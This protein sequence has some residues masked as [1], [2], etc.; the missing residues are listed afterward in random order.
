MKTQIVQTAQIAPNALPINETDTLSIT[1]AVVSQVEDIHENVLDW[2]ENLW[3]FMLKYGIK[4]LF[5]IIVFVLT[6]YL[7]QIF[8]RLLEKYL[9]KKHLNRSVV[10]FLVNLLRYGMILFSLAMITNTLG[11]STASILTLLGTLSLTIGLALQGALS[12]VAAGFLL[13]VLKPFEVGDI[14]ESQGQI[15]MV[16]KIEIFTTTIITKN[17]YLVILPNN[18]ITTD[19]VSNIS[20]LSLKRFEAHVRTENIAQVLQYKAQ[21][22]SFLLAQK[23]LLASEFGTIYKYDV[24]NFRFSVRF[25]CAQTLQW[26][27]L[28]KLNDTWQGDSKINFTY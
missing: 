13:L 8:V 4:V 11:L 15:G 2:N 6:L 5:A 20:R 26:E 27:L 24:K 16:D 3:E 17:H 9:K 1:E 18:K 14:I 22:Q 25:W 23:D 10:Y 12:N 7:V 19:R 28:Q 21:M